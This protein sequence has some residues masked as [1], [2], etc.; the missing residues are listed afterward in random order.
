MDSIRSV[1]LFATVVLA[2]TGMAAEHISIDRHQ[3]IDLPVLSSQVAGLD[4]AVTLDGNRDDLQLWLND[5]LL[6][7]LD[8]QHRT[9][10]DSSGY[11]Y[12]EGDIMDQPDSWARLTWV[13][14]AW[15][16]IIHVSG[17]TFLIDGRENVRAM[18]RSSE[19]SN[20]VNVAY[21][22][23]D[24]RFLTP[25]DAGGVN[26]SGT[27]DYSATAEIAG[28]RLLN[29]LGD[30]IA[31]G[32]FMPLVVVVDEQFAARHGSN[33][34]G[35][36]M[37]RLNMVDGI[38]IN[39]IGVGVKLHALSILND[40]ENLVATD[41]L[42]LL[43]EFQEYM[44][45][46]TGSAVSRPALGHLFTGRNL[47]GNVAGL[48]HMTVICSRT[49]GFGLSQDITSDTASALIVAHELGHNFGAPHDREP[50]SFCENSNIAG[51]MSALFGDSQQFSSCSLERMAD[52]V[53]SA[54][55]LET[56]DD[57]LFTGDFETV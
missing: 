24:L 36:V 53:A 39:Q 12:Y 49:Y 47:D 51:I 17:E 14:N 54:S 42:Q 38:Y 48:A 4:L 2:L 26:I 5:K 8:S 23:S 22:A 11:Y 40:N 52:D 41:A 25:I 37:S 15:Q 6:K 9:D 55:C 35:V 57:S 43:T 16:G 20:S 32:E 28:D 27:P 3:A 31:V 56:V 21:N 30:I 7:G 19:L 13:Q 1:A 44:R 50:G 29:L 18:L 45:F 34:T 10:L 46:G 33:T